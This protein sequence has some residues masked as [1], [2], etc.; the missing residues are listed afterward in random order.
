MPRR[1]KQSSRCSGRRLA[2]SEEEFRRAGPCTCLRTELG[3]KLCDIGRRGPEEL[4]VLQSQSQ[5]QPQCSDT[6]KC[7]EWA[8]LSREPRKSRED[9]V[10]K[11]RSRCKLSGLGIV[12]MSSSHSLCA[13]NSTLYLSF[14][15]D[16][17]CHTKHA[18]FSSDMSLRVPSDP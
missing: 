9:V 8:L 4:R 17:K 6:G 2:T 10:N 18:C 15:D 5:S 1:L 11:L 13:S 14:C 12:A 3:F 7:Q 16:C